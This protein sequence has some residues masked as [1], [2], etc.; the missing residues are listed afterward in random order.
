[1][2]YKSVRLVDSTAAAVKTLFTPGNKNA[3][4]ALRIQGNASVMTTPSTVW[5]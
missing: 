4:H 5:R 3:E 1:M 2:P